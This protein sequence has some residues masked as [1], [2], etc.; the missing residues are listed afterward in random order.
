MW[1]PSVPRAAGRIKDRQR[2]HLFPFKLYKRLELPAC[3]D[4]GGGKLQPIR[5][6]ERD[7]VPQG[8]GDTCD[9]LGSCPGDFANVKGRSPGV[10]R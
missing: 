10:T 8:N 6:P 9:S 7:S 4:A 5:T 1:S 2:C 3:E